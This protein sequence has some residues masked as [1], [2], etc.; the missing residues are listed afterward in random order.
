VKNLNSRKGKK[1][2]I[3]TV[4]FNRKT[5]RV[6]LNVLPL[7]LQKKSVKIV[8]F[9][10]KLGHQKRKTHSHECVFFL[11]SVRLAEPN[12]FARLASDSKPLANYR[13]PSP[14]QGAEARRGHQSKP[15]TNTT[16]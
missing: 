11:Q 13:L 4:N 1:Y 2:R 10:L 8:R 9:T 12:G 3:E 5:Y 14:Y 7:I 16:F 15:K 6:G